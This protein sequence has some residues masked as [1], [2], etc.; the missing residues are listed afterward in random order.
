MGV[1][2][3][4]TTS[5][6]QIVGNLSFNPNE[7]KVIQQVTSDLERAVSLG[8]LSVVAGSASGLNAVVSRL[9]SASAELP[10]TAV[11]DV[12]AT[13]TQAILNQNFA[14]LVDRLTT[15]AGKLDNAA[16]GAN[17]RPAV[18]SVPTVLGLDFSP[19]NT[20][21][22]IVSAA[23]LVA[24]DYTADSWANL[25]RALTTSSSI[26]GNNGVTQAQ[27]LG[28]AVSVASSYAALVALNPAPPPPIGCAYPFDAAAV[29]IEA[30]GFDGR[31]TLSNS[32]QTGTYTLLGNSVGSSFG[33]YNAL[34]TQMDISVAN[35]V[36][37]FN[38]VSPI[39]ATGGVGAG[40]NSQVS[41]YV[42]GYASYLRLE[43]A[44]DIGGT[45][46]MTV[47]TNAGTLGTAS[48]G[49][50]PL[51]TAGLTFNANTVAITVNGAP[52]VLSDNTFAHATVAPLVRITETA[53]VGVA[54][55]GKT[56]SVTF[57]SN[58]ADITEPVPVG[59]VDTC[60]NLR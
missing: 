25:Q 5:Q 22:G 57:L 7:S 52:V 30:T 50:T 35:T 34:Q 26:Q 53:V 39:L 11:A 10:Q 56:A 36:M 20:A 4:N 33:M 46:S 60:G 13:F 44:A 29:T 43:V 21:L 23:N 37:Q 45:L 59:A 31:L 49:T 32:D 8:Y 1:T 6:V 2:L 27:I 42:P 58:A 41:L 19:L 12:T 18:F 38:F 54:D 51:T 24:S 28:A 17:A 9:A 16:I 14:T 3:R 48:L 15:I 40:V 55:T 47:S